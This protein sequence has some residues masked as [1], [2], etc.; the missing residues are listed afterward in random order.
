MLSRNCWLVGV[1]VVVGVVALWWWPRTTTTP[2]AETKGHGLLSSPSVQSL[3]SLLDNRPRSLLEEQDTDNNTPWAYSKYATI[4]PDPEYAAPSSPDNDNDNNDDW[5]S[6][7][8][9]DDAEDERPAGDY[10]AGYPSRDIPVDDLADEAWQVDAVFVNH[11]L[12]SGEELV[13]RAQEVIFAEYGYPR[14]P[15]INEL[16]ERNRMFQWEK[17]DMQLPPETTPSFRPKSHPRR[18]DVP[19]QCRRFGPSFVTCHY[20]Q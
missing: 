11:M 8:F 6:W 9:W 2:R 20:D 7:H 5:G 16:L 14:N 13:Q 12:D 18:L 15:E 17:V 19:T 10:C 1:L 4:V 3:E